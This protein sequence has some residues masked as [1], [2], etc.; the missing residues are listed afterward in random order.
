[1]LSCPQGPGPNE[2]PPSRPPPSG[3]PPSGTGLVPL[4][5]SVPGPLIALASLDFPEPQ[6]TAKMIATAQRPKTLTHPSSL[7]P[8]PGSNGRRSRVRIRFRRGQ[9]S[10]MGSGEAGVRD[11]GRRS[12]SVQPI[13]VR[14]EVEVAAQKVPHQERSLLRASGLE[15]RRAESMSRGAVQHPV[16]V[17]DG[18]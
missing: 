4:P 10:R 1:M 11:A 13:F 16:L 17:E 3:L 7:L 18:E 14:L 15:N 12:P 5:P 9:N 2:I 8:S 6:P